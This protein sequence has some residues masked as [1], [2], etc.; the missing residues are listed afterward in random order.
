MTSLEYVH[1]PQTLFF[2]ATEFKISFNDMD[3]LRAFF[4]AR[5]N[6]DN[7]TD[8][9][10]NCQSLHYVTQSR[11]SLTA[12]A[13]FSESGVTWLRHLIEQTTGFYTGS[14]DHTAEARA[15][16]KA[17]EEDGKRV[18]AIN[19]HA[20]PS[21][22]R[23][24]DYQRAV[25]FV[26]D[27]R[28]AVVDHM[29]R[30][31]AS[32]LKALEDDLFKDHRRILIKYLI[33]GSLFEFEVFYEAWRQFFRGEAFILYE[34][35]L[36]RSPKKT[37]QKL[38]SFLTGSPLLEDVYACTEQ[39]YLHNYTTPVAVPAEWEEFMGWEWEKDSLNRVRARFW[40][41]IDEGLLRQTHYWNDAL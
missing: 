37:L 40:S 22:I 29:L 41:N 14:R 17:E 35:S 1:I 39:H 12:L 26:Q 18:V 16:F 5:L 8:E 33:K 24:V 3:N 2:D 4:F 34:K 10:I 20:M 23:S 27:T 32:K 15:N 30:K 13:S 19:T 6:A 25:V 7:S 36:K 31:H 38:I 9:N 11:R 28:S 21:A